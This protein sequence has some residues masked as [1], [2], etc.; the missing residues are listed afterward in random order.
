MNPSKSR[1]AARRDMPLGGYA[2]YISLYDVKREESSKV[3]SG[4]AD[5]SSSDDDHEAYGAGPGFII[6]DTSR[7][8]SSRDIYGS[9]CGCSKV[10]ESDVDYISKYVVD[11]AKLGSGDAAIKPSDGIKY[12]YMGKDGRRVE[13]NS[14]EAS[15]LPKHMVLIVRPDGTAEGSAEDGSTESSSSSEENSEDSD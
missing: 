12:Y 1:R 14:K 7:Y 6:G 2:R 8:V 5:D 11:D 10:P 3:G 4:Y 15:E 13:I 9:G